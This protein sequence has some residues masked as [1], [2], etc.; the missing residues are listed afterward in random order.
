MQLRSG[1]NTEY[2]CEN[3]CDYS[4]EYHENNSTEFTCVEINNSGVMNVIT[5]C[6]NI[7]QY[8]VDIVLYL[9]KTMWWILT[10]LIHLHCIISLTYCSI[11][12]LYYCAV[13]MFVLI[14]VYMDNVYYLWDAVEDIYN[15][16]QYNALKFLNITATYSF[17]DIML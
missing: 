17:E 15:V 12:V 10:T 1:K 4:C 5:S 9:C 13:I 11:W 16:S 6:Y 8:A 2:E 14:E 7:I 3:N